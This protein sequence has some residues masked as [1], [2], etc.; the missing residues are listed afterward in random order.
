MSGSTRHTCKPPARLVMTTAFVLASSIAVPAHV[1]KSL[2][3]P[4]RVTAFVSS[5]TAGSDVQIRIAWGSDTNLRVACF[6]VANTS[7]KDPVTTDDPRVT[8]VGLELPGS[9]T[10][11]ALLA[12]LDEGWRLHRRR[13]GLARIRRSRHPR[14][15]HRRH[16]QSNR[17][18]AGQSTGSRRN[19]LG[20]TRRSRSRY[21]FL[22]Q[23]TVSGRAAGAVNRRSDRHGANDNRRTAQ[24]RR[25]GFHG[26]DGS[27]QGRDA[28]VW[29][30]PP[31]TSARPIPLYGQ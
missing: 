13:R 16:R 5:P 28:G 12:P 1:I 8:S 2:D 30:P 23:R 19:Y 9:P 25:R 27:H 10:G 4:D 24:R 26:V 29:F 31:G 11:F 21:A 18:H 17:T 6:N 15:R 22:C 14:L 7:V 20:P 3:S